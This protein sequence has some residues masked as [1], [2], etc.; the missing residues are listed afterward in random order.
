[1][2]LSVDDENSFWELH[3]KV[4][5]FEGE[6]EKYTC[7]G[8][9]TYYCPEC[10]SQYYIDNGCFFGEVITAPATEREED[11][12]EI[13]TL[14]ELRPEILYFALAIEQV[15]KEKGDSLTTMNR[16]GLILKFREEFREIHYILV[17]DAFAESGFSEILNRLQTKL[18]DLGAV[19]GMLWLRTKEEQQ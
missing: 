14:Q 13:G 18:E 6:F 3:K 19:A 10:N 8:F 5:G 16:Y 15:L 4:C 7:L 9:E 12:P 17:D 1:M 2:T 11:Y